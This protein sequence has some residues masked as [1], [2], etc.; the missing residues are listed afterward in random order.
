MNLNWNPN[1]F[2]EKLNATLL[3]KMTQSTE[4]V[5][6]NIKQ[7]CPV[8]TGTLRDSIIKSMEVMGTKIKGIIKATA[9]YAW[10]VEFGTVKSAPRAFMRRGL[11]LS[12]SGIKDIFKRIV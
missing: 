10:W 3:Y 11:A 6:S 7:E 1:P 4:L 12:I 5:E 8:I 2:L 9:P